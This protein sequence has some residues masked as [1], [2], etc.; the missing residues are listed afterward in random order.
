MLV[1][2]TETPQYSQFCH[3][4]RWTLLLQEKEL[5]GFMARWER[6][7]DLV[8]NAVTACTLDAQG[9]RLYQV[10]SSK[11]HTRFYNLTLPSGCTCPDASTLGGR[12]PWGWCKHRLAAW[13][14]CR[15]LNAGITKGRHPE[16]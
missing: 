14:Y 11:D 6:A 10:T 8:P 9:H 4:H 2:G 16:R 7:Q 12:A 13:I 1:Q 15:W 3:Q 5:A